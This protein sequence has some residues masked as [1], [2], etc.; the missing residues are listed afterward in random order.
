MKEFYGII[1]DGKLKLLP[2]VNKLRKAH[3]DS[4]KN[5]TRVVEIIKKDFKPKTHQ[6]VKTIF[7]HMMGSIITQADDLGI[8]IS[9]LLVY[10]LDGNIPKGQG[11][12]RD[13]LHE[14][15]YIVSPTIDD[16]GNRVTL[17]KMNTKQ[18][19]ELFERF[20]NIFAPL[21]INIADPDWREKK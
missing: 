11:L 8:D 17:S 9:D 12:T 1:E 21:G 14:L 13:F 10:L 3:L 16:E 6:Q 5:G 7:G 20:R 18:A 4:I 19:S 2:A 15:M